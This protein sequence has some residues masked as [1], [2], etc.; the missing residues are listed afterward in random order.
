MED[1]GDGENPGVQQECEFRIFLQK[2]RRELLMAGGEVE[3]ASR[4]MG[5]GC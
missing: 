5:R 4:E 2:P 1:T 3:A